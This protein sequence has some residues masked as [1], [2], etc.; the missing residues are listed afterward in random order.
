[1]NG[2]LKRFLVF[3]IFTIFWGFT[4]PLCSGFEG[5]GGG[6]D[7]CHHMEPKNC[8]PSMDQQN[9]PCTTTITNTNIWRTIVFIELHYCSVI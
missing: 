5:G 3:I 8:R 1:M 4:I 6:G 7:L 2:A 9:L